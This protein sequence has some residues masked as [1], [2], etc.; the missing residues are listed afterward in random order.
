MF[1]DLKKNIEHEKKIIADMKSIT[2][3]MQID[4]SNHQFYISSLQS[5]LQQL[6][7]LNR[8]VPELL[9]EWS[10]VL[11]TGQEG[12]ISAGKPSIVAKN[13]VKMSYV[14]PTTKEKHFV[15]INK[16]DKK[17]F[18]E[19][20]QLSEGTFSKLKKGSEAE[21]SS[22]VEVRKAN[23]YAV[24]SNRYFRKYADR[25]VPYF[26]S[27]AQDMKLGNVQFLLATY[28]AMAMF[29]AVASFIL[30]GVLFLTLVAFSLSNWIFFWIP[31]GLS[32]LILAAF[33]F[34]PSNEASS[35]D[36][37]ISYEIPFATIYMAAIA[38]SDI[39]PTKLFRIIAA[40]KE[41]PNIGKEIRKVIIQTEIYGY[42]LVAALKNVA[43]RTPNKR[44]AELF[45]GL[46]TNIS[47]GGYLKNFLEKKAENFLLDYRLERQKYA[48]LAGTFMDVYI[49]ILIAAPLVLMMMF[50]VMNVSGMKL[51][52]LSI[53]S[54]LMISVLGIVVVNILFIFV[55]NL[56]QPKV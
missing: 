18:L 43:S 49:S 50:I 55:L 51:G 33:Y 19:K 6:Y 46:A 23:A 37:R 35:T 14:S 25:M 4:T 45:S 30:G 36:K 20:L 42:D 53:Q 12:Q 9:K 38:G 16:A 10:P 15:T 11:K 56:K 21:I 1:E 44:L 39:E 17:E 52:G 29:S 5:L 47:T 41:Y 3:S 28:L 8:S 26:G 34:Y 2:V 32:G 40:S 7:L 22:L 31:F 13:T 48:D 24:F 54:L 27:L